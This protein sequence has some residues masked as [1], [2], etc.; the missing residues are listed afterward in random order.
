MKSL[1]ETEQDKPALRRRCEI[2]QQMVLLSHGAD[3][4]LYLQLE[5]AIRTDSSARLQQAID[6]YEGKSPVGSGDGID[7]LKYGETD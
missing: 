6:S 3:H 5:E 7:P 1:T 4:P 2:L